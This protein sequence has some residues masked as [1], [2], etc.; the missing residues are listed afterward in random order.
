MVKLVPAAT[1]GL[2]ETCIDG[3]ADPAAVVIVAGLGTNFTVTP[4]GTA[5]LVSVTSPVKAPR[6]VTVRTSWPVPPDGMETD[7][8]AG[9][10]LKSLTVNGSHALVTALLLP[11]PLYIALKL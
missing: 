2:M 9:V 5:L 1:V 3:L 8:D 7:F 10:R 6:L 4:G 11:S